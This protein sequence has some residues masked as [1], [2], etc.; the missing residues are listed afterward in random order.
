MV[1]AI[2]NNPIGP[3]NVD[4]VQLIRLKYWTGSVENE[5]RLCDASSDLDINVGAGLET[6]IGSGLLISIS[7]VD[8]SSDLD[9]SGVDLAFDGVD[10]S[11]ISIILNNHFRGREVEVWRVWL[12]PST[13]KQ[14]TTPSVATPILMFKGF[15]N[16]TYQI[17]ESFTDNPD[18]VAVSTRI[19]GSISRVADQREVRSNMMSHNEMIEN[20]GLTDGDTFFQNVPRID[21]VEIFWGR[22]GE[23]TRWGLNDGYEPSGVPPW[24]PNG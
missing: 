12:E 10:Q 6:W 18:A 9:E 11:I 24:V 23:S 17:G 5:I 14:Q 19:V 2:N 1:R 21:G 4:V 8:E 3:T 20:A 22:K 13:G 15:Q 7:A 16:E